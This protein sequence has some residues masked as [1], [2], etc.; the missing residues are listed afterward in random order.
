MACL[1]LCSSDLISRGG[2]ILPVIALLW[3]HCFTK[4]ERSLECQ[5]FANLAVQAQFTCGVQRLCALDPQVQVPY[6][7]KQKDL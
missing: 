2:T 1:A 7:G 3:H 4:I 5:S 6:L